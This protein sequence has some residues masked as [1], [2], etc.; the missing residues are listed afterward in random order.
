MITLKWTTKKSTC[1]GIVSSLLITTKTSDGALKKNAT[2]WLKDQIMLLIR[3]VIVN[4]EIH[5]VL[6]VAAKNITHPVATKW[7]NGLSKKQ[8]AQK[9]SHGSRPTA[10]RVP[11]AT[12]TS[13]K[14]RAVSTWPA[15]NANMISAG[16]VLQNGG[17]M[18]LLQA[19]ITTARF[20]KNSKKLTKT[21]LQEKRFK[22]TAKMN[23]RGT[24]FILRGS[25]TTLNQETFVKSKWQLFR[26]IWDSWTRSRNIQMLNWPFLRTA[27]MRL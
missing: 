19:A 4:V 24:C 25:E 2:F 6:L 21:S 16:S 15:E 11:N 10:N 23:F 17:S 3:L 9:I 13:K 8:T 7:N 12:Q 5:F 1:S 22:K 20:T 27:Q 14:I 26:R 18:D